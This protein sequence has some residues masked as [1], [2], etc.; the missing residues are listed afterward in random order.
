MRELAGVR[1]LA[2]SLGLLYR[3]YQSIAPRARTAITA[4]TTGAEIHATKATKLSAT[5][6]SSH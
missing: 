3:R 4:Q 6:N 5:T 2:R 1:L